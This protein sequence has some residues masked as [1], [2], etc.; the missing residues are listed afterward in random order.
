MNDFWR[1]GLITK[2]KESSN[3]L[4]RTES[5]AVLKDSFPKARHHF[6]ILPFDESLDTICDLTTDMADLLDEFELLATNLVELKGGKPE[7]YKVGFH[8]EPSMSR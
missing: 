5:L 4:L 7:H 8:M 1:T 2:L 3:I 6:L